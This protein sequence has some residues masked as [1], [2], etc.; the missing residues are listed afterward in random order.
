M[1]EREMSKN[2]REMPF[3]LSFIIYCIHLLKC[4]IVVFGFCF[5]LSYK[6]N[7]SLHSIPLPYFKKGKKNHLLESSRVI[8]SMTILRVSNSG[9]QLWSKI[10]RWLLLNKIGFTE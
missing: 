9:S 5:F 8:I 4:S 2:W 6:P 7:F 3:F 1:R 10:T